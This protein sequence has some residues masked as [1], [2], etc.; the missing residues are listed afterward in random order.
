MLRFASSY[1]IDK[2]ILKDFVGS[3]LLDSEARTIGDRLR[4]ES[5]AESRSG[6]NEKDGLT[7]KVSDRPLEAPMC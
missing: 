5:V 1:T 2:P 3:V 7:M 4:L 6:K